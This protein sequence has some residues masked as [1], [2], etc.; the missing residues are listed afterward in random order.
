MILAGG[1]LGIGL[2]WKAILPGGDFKRQPVRATLAAAAATGA[3][4]SV[5]ASPARDEDRL[6][7]TDLSP[8]TITMGTTRGLLADPKVVT[9]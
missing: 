1:S 5:I 2:V 9:A 4:S 3:V 8:V 6:T 7:I